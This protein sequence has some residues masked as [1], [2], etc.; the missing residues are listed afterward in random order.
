MFNTRHQ[1][2]FQLL[3]LIGAVISFASGCGEGRARPSSSAMAPSLRNGEMVRVAHNVADPNAPFSVPSPRLAQ[4][5]QLLDINAVPPCDP[6][7]LS[8]FE[9]RAEVNGTHH[10]VRFSL[11][12]S[13]QACRL[14]GFPSITLL[15]PDGSIVGG[16]RIRKISGDTM[17]ASLTSPATIHTDAGLDAPSPQ[18]LLASS[19]E[20]AFELGWTSGP[21]CESVSRI[22]LA[23]PGS[24]VSMQVSRSISVC[25]SQVLI[26]AVAPSDPR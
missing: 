14:G 17:R 3:L 25:E 16:V 6:S 10:A 9:S 22:A 7:A 1:H 11:V 19:E 8:V 18:V 5:P 24:M 26:T 4:R 23:A 15:R 12:N 2:G 20:A 13:G 21:R